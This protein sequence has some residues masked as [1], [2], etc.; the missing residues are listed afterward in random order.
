LVSVTLETSPWCVSGVVPVSLAANSG[1]KFR[2]DRISIYH[3]AKRRATTG[4]HSG[5]LN[6]VIIITYTTLGVQ[7]RSAEFCL[8]DRKNRVRSLTVNLDIY[9]L[10]D[11]K[12]GRRVG[13]LQKIRELCQ[14]GTC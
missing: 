9:G 6:T 8:V 10:G 13:S 3:I 11:I 7:K 14:N 1:G 4:S 12:E 5:T 2:L